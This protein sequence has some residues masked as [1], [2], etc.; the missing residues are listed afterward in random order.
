MA[1]A[2]ENAWFEATGAVGN[3]AFRDL[4]EQHS[5]IAFGFGLLQQ[6]ARHQHPR[7]KDVLAGARKADLAWLFVMQ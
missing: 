7:R 2:F 3:F 6:T 4:F 1:A 5:A